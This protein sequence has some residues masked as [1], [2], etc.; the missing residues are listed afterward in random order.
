MN[1]NE[2]E[3][4]IDFTEGIEHLWLKAAQQPSWE[5][6]I[7]Q[8]KSKLLHLCPFTAHGCISYIRHYEDLINIAMQDGSSIRY[9]TSLTNDRGT[10]MAKELNMT[11]HSIQKWAKSTYSAQQSWIP[12][13]SL[14]D[15]LATQIYQALCFS[16]IKEL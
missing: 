10:S 3:R 2:L 13:C 6:A 14:M 16:I 8:I 12:S 11:F 7:E 5:S 1:A 4:F 9:V 15:T